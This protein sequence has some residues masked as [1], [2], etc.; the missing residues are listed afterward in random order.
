M[1]LSELLS[2]KSGGPVT[3][4]NTATVAEAIQAMHER[5]V[6]SVIIAKGG[7]RPQ[8]ILTERDVLGLCARGK[9]GELE[10]LNVAEC[11]TTDVVTATPDDTI[12]AMLGL[13]TERRFRH[14]PVIEH[15]RLVGLVS[16]G[17]LVKAKLRETAEEA[18]ALRTYIQT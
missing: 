17:D 2:K 14:V 1:K 12:D 18:E 8:G 9:G 6:G 13:M 7:D 5:K 16:I 15:D 10:Q 11:M 4:E 3:V